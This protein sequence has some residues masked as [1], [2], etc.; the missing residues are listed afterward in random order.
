MLQI[1]S[2][3][4]LLECFRTQ[5]QKTVIPPTYVNYP[6]QADLYYTWSEPSGVYQYLIFQKTGWDSPIGI[7]FQRNGQGQATS[8]AG[9]CE[10]CHAVGPS[11]QVGLLTTSIHS[12]MSGGTYLCIDLS[13]AQ[14]LIQAAQLSH[15]PIEPKLLKLKDRITRFFDRI[16]FSA[17][18]H[19]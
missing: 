14:K 19:A 11:D 8:P 18:S 3:Q 10:W 17:D 9:L 6:I 1:K 13:C 16:L 2:E 5:D 15:Q 4:K 7:T 12:R